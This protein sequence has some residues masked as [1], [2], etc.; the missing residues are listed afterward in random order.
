MN[1][2]IVAFTSILDPSA[3]LITNK[4]PLYLRENVLLAPSHNASQSSRIC[5]SPRVQPANESL[6]TFS[7]SIWNSLYVTVGS[8]GIP[9]LP[10]VLTVRISPWPNPYPVCLISKSITLDP[11]PTT[12]SIV[13]Y[14]PIPEEDSEL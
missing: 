13:A 6:Y 1:I 2:K 5:I 14:V 4:S 10:P 8:V 3:D 9:A 12:T 7:I 11:W